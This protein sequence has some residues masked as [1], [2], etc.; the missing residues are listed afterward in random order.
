M[1]NSHQANGCSDENDRLI[2]SSIISL[3]KSMRLDVIAEGVETAQQEDFLVKLG[4]VSIQ[5]YL[6]S[7]PVPEKEMTSL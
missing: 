1:Q 5:G 7:R 2:V 6:Y 3:A 4:C